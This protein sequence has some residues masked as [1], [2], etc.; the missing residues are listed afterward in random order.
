MKLPTFRRVFSSDY[1]TQYKQLLDALS[2]TINTGI[3]VLYNVLNN[4]VSLSDNIACTVGTFTVKVNSDGSLPSTQGT[5]ATVKLNNTQTV[6]GVV[7]LNVTDTSTTGSSAP[8]GAVM[9]SYSVSGQTL[10][11]T[12][13]TGL[14]ASHSYN[15]K[16]VAFN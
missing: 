14:I 11:I 8:A 4:N 6:Q 3:E 15:I 2:G 12:S 7:V 16:V 5:V 9:V 1:N 10:N 13:V